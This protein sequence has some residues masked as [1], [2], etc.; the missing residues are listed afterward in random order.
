MSQA[1]S[2]IANWVIHISALIITE[3]RKKPFAQNSNLGLSAVDGIRS[4]GLA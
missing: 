1:F 3:P 4:V 2:K